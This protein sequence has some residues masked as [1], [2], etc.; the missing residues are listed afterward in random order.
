MESLGIPHTSNGRFGI[1]T[2][3]SS[4]EKRIDEPNNPPLPR[5]VKEIELAIMVFVDSEDAHR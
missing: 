1:R 3:P 2:Q 4:R 5:C